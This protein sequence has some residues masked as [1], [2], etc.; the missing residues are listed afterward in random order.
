[1]IP[2]SKIHHIEHDYHTSSQESNKRRQI[3]RII[4]CTQWF[5]WVKNYIM[6]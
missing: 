3:Q 4:T 6:N 5:Q 2:I 1:M